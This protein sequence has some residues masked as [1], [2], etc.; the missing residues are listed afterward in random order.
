LVEGLQLMLI[1]SNPTLLLPYPN[2]YHPFPEGY[3]YFY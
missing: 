3:I 2:L 1:D